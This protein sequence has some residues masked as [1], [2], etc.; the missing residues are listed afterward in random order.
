LLLDDRMAVPAGW[1]K[2]EAQETQT[3]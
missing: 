1:V 2:N 3:L